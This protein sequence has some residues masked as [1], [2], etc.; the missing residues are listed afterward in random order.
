MLAEYVSAN[1]LLMKETI[2]LKKTNNNLEQ[3]ITHLKSERVSKEHLDPETS[4]KEEPTSS[5]GLK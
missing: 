2:Q 3:E 4:I 5:Q 1:T